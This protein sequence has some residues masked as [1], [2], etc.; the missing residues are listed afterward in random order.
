MKT[1]RIIGNWRY[2]DLMRQTPRSAGRWDDVLFTGDKIRECD[3]LI[4]LN[5]SAVDEEVSCRARNVWC[6]HQEPPNEY[7]GVCHSHTP[8]V[9]HRV[10]TTDTGLK[11]PRYVHTH[12]ALPW[13]VDKCYDELKSA[14]LPEKSREVS[15]ITSS[16][17]HFRGHRKRLEFARRLLEKLPVDCFGHGIRSLKDKW[18][19]L[20]PYR[21]S[22]AIENFSSAHY[23][24]EKLADCFLAWTMPVY[25]GCSNLSDYF[26]EESFIP[27]D[28][29]NPDEAADIIREAISRNAWGRNYDAVSH[30]RRLVLEKY[31]FFPFMC[32]FLSEWE[33]GGVEGAPQRIRI[34]GEN[35]PSRRIFLYFMRRFRYLFMPEKRG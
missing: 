27:I 28:V 18:D 9:Y 19:G 8:A 12:G 16:K 4:V 23:W 22:I 15:M 21:Y 1:V 33:T 10:F 6:L 26:P 32:R 31:Q 20:S 25:Y 3:Y 2:P 14:A 34:P 5:H 17:A 11:G 35:R 13:H 7:F 24:T 29:T 30:A